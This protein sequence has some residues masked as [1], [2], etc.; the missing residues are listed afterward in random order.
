MHSWMYKIHDMAQAASMPKPVPADAMGQQPVQDSHDQLKAQEDQEDEQAQDMAAQVSTGAM[1]SSQ[2]GAPQSNS[3]SLNT[4]AVQAK[5][6]EALV[7]SMQVAADMCM[8]GFRAT[9]TCCIDSSSCRRNL[10]VLCREQMHHLLYC[11]YMICTPGRKT[12]NSFTLHWLLFI[13]CSIVQTMAT[14]TDI[15]FLL[16]FCKL[17]RRL[18]VQQKSHHQTRNQQTVSNENN[19]QIHVVSEKFEG[20]TSEER[21]SLIEQV[22][23]HNAA[24]LSPLY[25]QHAVNAAVMAS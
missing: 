1:P 8:L 9:C 6:Q 4:Q 22:S 20:M 16:S 12:G 18:Q 19:F 11:L 15:E 21:Q 5:L 13:C 23:L 25:H 10:V 3:S 14:D 17:L 24:T 2:S 7:P